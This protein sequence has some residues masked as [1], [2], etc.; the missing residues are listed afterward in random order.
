MKK[1]FHRKKRSDPDA[2]PSQSSPYSGRSEPGLRTS[3]YDTT[4]ASGLPQTGDYPIRGN[5]TPNVLRK[6]PP[7]RRSS[8]RSWRSTSSQQPVPYNRSATPDQ[9]A[10]TQL[11]TQPSKRDMGPPESYAP[12]PVGQRRWSRSQLPHD[13]SNLNLGNEGR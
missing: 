9:Y 13:F 7:S 5:D 8:I 11:S 12:Q 4:T 6:K 2:S 10:G 1:L 3:L